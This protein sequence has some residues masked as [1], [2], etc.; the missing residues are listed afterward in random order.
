VV[1]GNASDLCRLLAASQPRATCFLSRGLAVL[2]LTKIPDLQL[3]AGFNT[4][5]DHESDDGVRCLPPPL[6]AALEPRPLPSAPDQPR[7]TQPQQSSSSNAAGAAALVIPRPPTTMVTLPES[8]AA[9]E[10]AAAGD[11]VQTGPVSASPT[12]LLSRA[13]AQAALRRLAGGR[14]GGTSVSSSMALR[15][16]MDAAEVAASDAPAELP[17][18]P[19]PAAL[20]APAVQSRITLPQL[21]AGPQA[22]A[23]DDQQQQEPED[24]ALAVSPPP[25][26]AIDE[27]N[28]DDEAQCLPDSAAASPAA[29]SLAAAQQPAVA[30]QPAP[31]WQQQ[32]AA[33]EDEPAAVLSPVPATPH[34]VAAVVRAA[35]AVSF[36]SERGAPSPLQPW[37]LDMM[38]GAAALS[39]VSH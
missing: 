3:E 39:H 36:A 21:L 28:S 7:F 8:A 6:P 9:A 32:D 5:E 26:E 19:Q 22:S 12:A 11:Q 1:A 34:P 13:E 20:P 4:V 27:G 18:A 37:M 38:S 23:R 2:C 30:Q 35:A 29:A 31:R 10:P 15:D 16:S 17:L 14:A 25:Q 33:P 24:V